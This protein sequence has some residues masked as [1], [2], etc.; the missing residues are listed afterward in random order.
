LISIGAYRKGSNPNVDMAVALLDDI[1]AFLRQGIHET[2]GMPET[3]AAMIKLVERSYLPLPK[4]AVAV[5]GAAL[6]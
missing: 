6:G 3:R 5:G 2:A 4:P 1:H